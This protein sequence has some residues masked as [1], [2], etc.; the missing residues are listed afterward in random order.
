MGE[1]PLLLWGS[2]R[3]F[4]LTATYLVR[5]H[6]FSTSPICIRISLATVRIVQEVYAHFRLDPECC[7]G[8]DLWKF[9][10]L[11]TFEASIS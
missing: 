7:H 11:F 9:A 1:Y 10:M 5:V 4:L 3:V 6:S 8:F 2:C